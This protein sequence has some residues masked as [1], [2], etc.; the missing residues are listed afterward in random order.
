MPV[1]HRVIRHIL[2]HTDA[3]AADSDVS[4]VAGVAGRAQ[5]VRNA[6]QGLVADNRDITLR[7]LLQAIFDAIPSDLDRQSFRNAIANMR[8]SGTTRPQL[9]IQAWVG[10]GQE[11]RGG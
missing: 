9:A 4:Q 5:L 11:S 2:H 6:V 10:K 8:A 7:D 3:E 1:V